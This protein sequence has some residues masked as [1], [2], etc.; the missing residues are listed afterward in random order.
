MTRTK[1]LRL[2][3]VTA[4][5]LGLALLSAA[6]AR[7]GSCLGGPANGHYCGSSLDCPKWCEGGLFHHFPCSSPI[8]C[9]K[10]CVGGFNSG[11]SC[12]SSTQCPGGYCQQWS[13]PIISCSPTFASATGEEAAAFC[14]ADQAYYL[15]DVPKS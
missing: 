6:P 1:A 12:N 11:F 10:T 9:G 14:V 7:G 5:L 2:L 4:S 13:C 3:C 15:L 8:Q